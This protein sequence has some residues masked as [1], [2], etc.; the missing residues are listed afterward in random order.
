MLP[1]NDLPMLLPSA[2]FNSQPAANASSTVDPV[3][4]SLAGCADSLYSTA[5]AP[6][7][8]SGVYAYFKGEPMG[9]L[10]ACA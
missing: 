1:L 7:R 5:L 4:S 6:N 10:T 8:L 2:S 3:I 9:V